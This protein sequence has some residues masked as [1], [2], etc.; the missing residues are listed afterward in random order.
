M[1]F[2]RIFAIFCLFSQTGCDGS[3]NDGNDHNETVDQGGSSS[4]SSTDS[5]GGG[6]V[7]SVSSGGSSNGCGT[8]PRESIPSE[9]CLS[10]QKEA[11]G[12]LAPSKCATLPYCTTYS[13]RPIV[14]KN[15]SE[16]LS[17]AQPIYCTHWYITCAGMISRIT[18]PN[19]N[20]WLVPSDCNIPGFTIDY[21]NTT[22]LQ[23]CSGS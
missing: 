6:G 19:G 8:V 2:F 22:N 20:T 5:K 4:T 7:S 23:D 1:K 3:S 11:C 10:A 18:A 13:G 21:S 12:K 17:T 9:I 16:C 14:T 15:G